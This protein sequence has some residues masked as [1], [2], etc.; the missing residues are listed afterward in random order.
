MA[1]RL[2]VVGQLRDGDTWETIEQYTLDGKREQLGRYGLVLRHSHQG[3]GFCQ[4]LGADNRWIS[5]RLR[6]CQP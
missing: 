5:G 1:D 2:S 6:Y 3:Q 4:R